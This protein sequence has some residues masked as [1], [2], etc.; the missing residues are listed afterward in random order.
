MLFFQNDYEYFLFTETDTL[1]FK[2]LGQMHVN[3]M[4]QSLRRYAGRTSDTYDDYVKQTKSNMMLLQHPTIVVNLTIVTSLLLGA[5][6]IITTVDLTGALAIRLSQQRPRCIILAVLPSG[7][8]ELARKLTQWKCIIPVLY[9]E[10]T[11]NASSW[12]HE[13]KKRLKFGLTHAKNARMVAVGDLVI[14]CYDL[15]E[16]GSE[17]ECLSYQTSYLAE[18]IVYCTV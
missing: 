8:H 9:D 4:K 6:L 16:D 5:S 13:V 11:P 7:A 14:Y 10:L 18:E 17:T 12:R 3:E 1:L 15:R 2:R